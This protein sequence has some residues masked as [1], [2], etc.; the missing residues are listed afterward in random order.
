MIITISGL[1][2]TGKSTIG[3]KLA[4]NLGIRYYSTGQAFR[5]LANEGMIPG[6]RKSSW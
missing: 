3:K 5:E 1:H 4:E 2:G 6:V